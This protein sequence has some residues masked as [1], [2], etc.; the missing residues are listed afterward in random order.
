MIITLTTDFGL[1]DP[2]VGI[3]KGVILSIAPEAQLV[4]IAHDIPS[5]DILEAAFIIDSAFRYFP[6]KTI[7]L[8]V[9]DP[10]VGG[11][12]RPIAASTGDQYFVAPD[13]GVLSFI[14]NTGPLTPIPT[15]HIT[16]ASLF[17]QPVSK[18]FHGRDIFAPVAGHL[19][20]GAPID[21]VGPRIV[22]FVR[23]SSP[24]PR[25]NGARALIATVLRIDRFGN[26]IT[27]LQRGD[28][29]DEFRSKLAMLKFVVSLPAMTR[30]SPAN[31]SRLREAQATL[32]CP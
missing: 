24:R 1:R 30:A 19:A 16:N 7:H 15:Y 4:D 9:V 2:F 29:T 10:G 28:L 31:S 22:D 20:R 13:N 25:R 27:N 14:L 17:H 11:S 3:M 21:S 23:K 32:N 26:I 12:R 8:V 18:T 5:H 6:P